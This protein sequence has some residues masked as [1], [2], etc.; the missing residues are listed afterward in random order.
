[1]RPAP[2]ASSTA[3]APAGAAA[4]VI[5]PA[6]TEKPAPA[7]PASPAEAATE[8]ELR[9]RFAKDLLQNR[10]KDAVATLGALV[11]ANPRVAE[12]RQV[13][14]DVVELSQR[15]MNVDGPEPDR[16]FELLSKEMDTVGVDI[17]YELVTTRGGS[18]AA[19]RAD[20]LIRDESVRDR[21][22]EAMRVAYDFRTA[23][24]CEDKIALFDRA[25]DDGDGRTL[26]QLQLLN[27]SCGRRSGDCC[28]HN[29]PRLKETIE[30]I[31]SRQK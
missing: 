18:K 16:M 2:A 6:A 14:A 9:A 11:E 20:E 27:R 23:R 4:A 15:I 7:A 29:D 24:K 8:R 10:L 21:G 1:M 3:R 19:K 31:K 17:L 30:A 25:K 13:R 26:G 12:D 22:S 5:P 28:L